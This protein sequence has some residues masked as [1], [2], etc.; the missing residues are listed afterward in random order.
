MVFQ[1]HKLYHFSVNISSLKHA[2]GLFWAT[3]LS[4]RCKNTG[5]LMFIK[6]P[7]ENSVFLMNENEK[8]NEFY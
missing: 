8:I 1:K 5:Q 6:S 2:V 7:V 4:S 3:I